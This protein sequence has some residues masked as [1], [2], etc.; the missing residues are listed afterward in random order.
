ML[1]AHA[2]ALRVTTAEAAPLDVDR[3]R[4][5]LVVRVFKGGLAAFLAHDHVVRATAYD[6]TLDV[7][8]QPLAI[9]AEIR[10]DVSA[11][12]VDDP[13]VRARHGLY[14]VLSDDDRAEVRA[15]MLGPEQLDVAAHPEIVF[16]ASEIDRYGGEYRLAGE[17]SL[18]GVAKRIVM[19]VTIAESAGAFTAQGSVRILQSDHGIVPYRAMLGAV[20]NRDEIELVVKVV[21]TPR[22]TRDQSP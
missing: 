19:P 9:A 17:L 8:R 15:T 11:L 4:S 10:V 22:G 14:G 13:A 2:S 16:R 18:H 7:T 5:E 21:A 1:V 20:R 6:A 12:E 3:E